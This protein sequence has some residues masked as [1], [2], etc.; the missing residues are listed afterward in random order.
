[1]M[2]PFLTLNDNTEITHSEMRKDGTVKVYIETPD[3]KDCFHSV[4]CILPK[5]EWIE[6]N[7]FTDNEINYFKEIIESTAHLILKFAEQGGFK[8]ASDI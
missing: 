2:Y 3:E 5:Y 6:N 4:V 7:G 1:M 8:V